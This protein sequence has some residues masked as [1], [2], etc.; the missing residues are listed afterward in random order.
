M[1]N[2]EYTKL[3]RF[4]AKAATDSGVGA[5]TCDMYL[6]SAG[7]T[8]EAFAGSAEGEGGTASVSLKATGS[9]PPEF[10]QN[11]TK[12]RVFYRDLP[13]GAIVMVVK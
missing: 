3:L 2:D 6:P 5:S 7:T 4:A 9:E 12:V 1:T 8:A 11:N 13:E 10:R